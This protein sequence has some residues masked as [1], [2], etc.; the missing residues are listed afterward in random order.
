[1]L[2]AG[3]GLSSR[4]DANHVLSILL[5]TGMGHHYNETSNRSKGLL[6]LLVIDNPVDE[7]KRMWIIKHKRRNFKR[8]PVLGYVAAVFRLIPFKAHSSVVTSM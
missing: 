7:A 5:E 1:M 4:N 6:S 2:F 8:E 3:H